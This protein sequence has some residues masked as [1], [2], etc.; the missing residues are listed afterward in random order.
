LSIFRPA[1]ITAFLSFLVPFGS[2]ISPEGTKPAVCVTE[3]GASQT[4]NAEQ[5][6][7]GGLTNDPLPNM[8]SL[9]L[10]FV[11][12]MVSDDFLPVMCIAARGMKEV[13]YRRSGRLM[14]GDIPAKD[15]AKLFS[16]KATQSQTC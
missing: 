7:D 15:V 9:E 5:I 10:K 1:E 6:T 13:G 8:R 2:G 3:R 16:V 12:T 14:N 11:D 4:R